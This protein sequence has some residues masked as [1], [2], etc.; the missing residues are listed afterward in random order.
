M[1]IVNNSDIFPLV[2]Q[3]SGVAFAI[4]T[5]LLIWR[6][7]DFSSYIMGV[8]T[9]LVLIAIASVLPKILM[10]YKSENDKW[11]KFSKDHACKVVSKRDGYSSS[12]VGITA[13]G[14][15]GVVVGS[16]TPGQTAY[17]CDDGI[18]YWKNH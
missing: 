2:V 9:M 4:L 7:V 14:T 8:G 18:I 16:G 5:G 11:E 10:S 12:G 6:L 13:K 15:M 3:I 17:E 1:Q